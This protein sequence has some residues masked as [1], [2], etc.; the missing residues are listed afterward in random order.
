MN[1]KIKNFAYLIALYFFSKVV[2]EIDLNELQEIIASSKSNF[3]ISF[4]FFILS[5]LSI[6]IIWCKFIQ[7]H[8]NINFKISFELWIKSIAAKYIP[9]KISS[10]ILRIE[11]ESFKK[12]KFEFYNHILIE[13]LILILISIVFGSYIFLNSI[14]SFIWHFLIVNFLFFLFF[15]TSNLKIKKFNL[16]YIKNI[17][18]LEISSLLNIF[19][20]YFLTLSFNKQNNLELVFVYI[21]VSGISMLIFIIPAGIGIRENF[22]IQLGNSKNYDEVF[23]ASLGVVIRASIIIV[24]LVFVIIAFLIYPKINHSK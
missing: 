2:F 21:F 24:D 22:F 10:P 8:Y 19:G 16:T 4:L 18:Y 9:G 5:Q 1:K 11:N 12:N 17:F 15:M 7:K 23:L 3:Y 20:I 6:G 14:F 13:N